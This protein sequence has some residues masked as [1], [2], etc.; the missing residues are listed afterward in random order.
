[1]EDLSWRNV[2]W[3][4]EGGEGEQGEE[5]MQRALA[6]IPPPRSDVALL[7]NVIHILQARRHVNE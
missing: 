1:M 3:Q 2:L 6:H 4:V 5:D 7:H